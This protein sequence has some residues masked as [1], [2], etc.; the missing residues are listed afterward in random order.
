MVEKRET[1]KIFTYRG[2]YKWDYYSKKSN[3]GNVSRRWL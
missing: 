3:E 2:R 1:D